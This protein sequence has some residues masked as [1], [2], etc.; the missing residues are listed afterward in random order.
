MFISIKKHNKEI[1][2]ERGITD[3]VIR[4]RDEAY[5]RIERLTHESAGLEKELHFRKLELDAAR[6]ELDA[7]KKRFD[8]LAAMTRQLVDVNDERNSQLDAADEMLEEAEDTIDALAQEL[9]AATECT[10]KKEKRHG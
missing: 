2:S 8:H 10:N 4:Q 9:E 6:Q 5:A 3:L 1:V 7:W